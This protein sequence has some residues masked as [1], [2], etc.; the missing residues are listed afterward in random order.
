MAAT[1]RRAARVEILSSQPEVRVAMN[2]E[3]LEVAV[4]ALE[5]ARLGGLTATRR[6]ATSEALESKL[7]DA[8]KRWHP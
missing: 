6:V 8:L 1:G 4:I 3:E 7:Y 5:R 2:R